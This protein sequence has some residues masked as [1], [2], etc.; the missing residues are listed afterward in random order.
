MQGYWQEIRKVVARGQKRPQSTVRAHNAS[1]Q[2]WSQHLTVLRK[3]IEAKEVT[4]I[5]VRQADR[6]NP[7][8]NKISNATMPQ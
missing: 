6:I 1:V 7:V 3:L 2:D 4:P 8:T 5:I